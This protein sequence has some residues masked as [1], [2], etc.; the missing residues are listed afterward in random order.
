MRRPPGSIEQR[1]RQGEDLS[2]LL[3]DGAKPPRWT[4][5]LQPMRS[6]LESPSPAAQV[7]LLIEGRRTAFPKVNVL[8]SEPMALGAHGAH[9]CFLELAGDD[10]ATSTLVA[11]WL[12][13]AMG[14]REFLVISA[15]ADPASFPSIEPVL[16]ESFRS[17]TVRA[18]DDVVAQREARLLDGAKFLESIDEARLRAV[19]G[20]DAWYRIYQ[21]GK[22]EA[23][24][25]IGGLHVV[26]D[27]GPFGAVSAEKTPDRFT[28]EDQR[29]GLL[30]RVSMRQFLGEEGTY[31]SEST[32]W[33][34]WD[35]SEEAWAIRG[36]RRY[37]NRTISD[38]V[39]GFRSP[40]VAGDPWGTLL[41]VSSGGRSGS[42]S[43]IERRVPDVYLP[44]ALRWVLGAIRPEIGEQGKALSAYS[45]EIVPEGLSVVQRIDEWRVMKDGRIELTTRPRADDARTTTIFST[46]GRLIRRTHP[47]GSVAE[48]ITAENLRALWKEHGLN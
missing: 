20:T 46:E 38:S 30:V 1:Q 18:F 16:L 39:T 41:V 11:G 28:E 23:A 24:T 37:R 9:V 6:T 47:D 5:R 4:M 14:E 26:I 19:L 35:Q 40:P 8:R 33:M 15:Q 21:P 10:A 31:D 12:C 17:I 25:E 42:T 44:Q 34:A 48:P 27:A 43:T 2:I 29:I 36:T 13:L 3:T 7:D 45:V 22:G 32:Y